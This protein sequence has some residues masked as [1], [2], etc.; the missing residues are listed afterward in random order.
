MP[1]W[2]KT[3]IAAAAVSVIITGC[4]REPWWVNPDVTW[5][6]TYGGSR[7]EVASDILL[8]SDGSLFIVGHARQSAA[9]GRGADV[10]VIRKGAS[11]A[12]DEWIAAVQQSADGGFFLAGNIVAPTTSS[13]TQE[14]RG[15]VALTVVAACS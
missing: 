1:G 12:L 2:T 7:S 13:R 8:G 4:G 6:E 3:K 5:I 14:P 11:G 9:S 10:Y 15:T